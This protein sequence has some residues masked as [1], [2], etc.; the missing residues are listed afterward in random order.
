[1]ESRSILISIHPCYTDQIL[2]GKKRIE[3]RRC[4]AAYPVDTIVIYATSPVQHIVAVARVKKVTLA[5][6]N[7]LCDLSV[8]VGGGISKNKLISYLQGKKKAYGIELTS[9]RPLKTPVPLINIFGKKVRA[10]QSF[11]YVDKKDLNRLKQYLK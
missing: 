1:M 8:K 6:P 2:S 3:F 5:S 11:S 4:W 9:V 7:T 10:P